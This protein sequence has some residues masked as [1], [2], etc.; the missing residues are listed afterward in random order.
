[1]RIVLYTM[2]ECILGVYDWML[3]CWLDPV[4]EGATSTPYLLH[5][6]YLF[7]YCW[8]WH[9]YAPCV[10]VCGVCRVCLLFLYAYICS[11]VVRCFK[12]TG[13]CVLHASSV[14]N[15]VFWSQGIC[16]CIIFVMNEDYF[17]K[18]PYLTD[19]CLGDAACFHRHWNR[20][21]EYSVSER[22][23]PTPPHPPPPPPPPPPQHPQHHAPRQRADAK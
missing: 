12:L 13:N 3:H 18:L 14:G 5:K 22:L 7:S 1:M 19:L 16:G 21:F 11:I 15:W 20:N 6:F 23:S 17:H 2:C 10:C 4:I 9:V 8:M